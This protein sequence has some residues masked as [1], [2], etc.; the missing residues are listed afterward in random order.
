[1][2]MCAF[3]TRYLLVAIAAAE[4]PEA[5]RVLAVQSVLAA[6]PEALSVLEAQSQAAGQVEQQAATVLTQR[7][8]AV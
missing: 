7:S 3:L 4:E 1:M 6:L 8:F 5:R 2:R